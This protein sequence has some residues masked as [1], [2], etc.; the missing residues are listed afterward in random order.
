MDDNFKLKNMKNKSQSWLDQM[1]VNDGLQITPM[2]ESKSLSYYSR[3][4]G[5]IPSNS[6]L[7]TIPMINNRYLTVLEGQWFNVRIMLQGGV[8][9]FQSTILSVYRVPSNYMHLDFPHKVEYK[10]VR[11]CSRTSLSE[12]IEVYSQK[13]FSDGSKISVAEIIDISL[14]GALIVASIQL[15][16]I[17]NT[18]NIK[19]TFMMRGFS[20][21]M[22]ISCI[23]RQIRIK[24]DKDTGQAY[25]EHGV[26]F[27]ISDGDNKVFLSDYVNEQ[28]IY[29]TTIKLV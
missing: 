12:K 14:G 3:Y 26:S 20:R 8:Y 22:D 4:I 6:I 28:L 1:S 5:Y 13:E 18:I 9:A 17:G 25:S 27:E 10:D 11:A 29:A 24:E 23:I 15:G 21:E 7:V 2:T 19:G 16:A